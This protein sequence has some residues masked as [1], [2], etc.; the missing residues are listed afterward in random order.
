MPGLR[1]PVLAGTPFKE[2]VVDARGLGLPVA[3]LNRRL[4]DLGFVG[5]IDLGREA[6]GT[7]LDDHL[8]VCVTEVHDADDIEAFADA[9]EQAAG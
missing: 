2:V 8:L 9:I 4:L 3:E 7:G 1:A 5:A 6:P